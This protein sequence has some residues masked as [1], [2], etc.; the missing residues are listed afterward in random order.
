MAMRMTA[1][2]KGEDDRGQ[3]SEDAE[4]AAAA[5]VAAPKPL[6]MRLH[7]SMVAMKVMAPATEATYGVD[8]DVLVA[9]V[10]RARGR[11]RR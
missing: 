4:G 3:D 1:A 9:D 8:E 11:R 6:N 7:W 10:C 2:A 5:T